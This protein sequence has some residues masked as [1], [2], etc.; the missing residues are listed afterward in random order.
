MPSLT[1]LMSRQCR[2]YRLIVALTPHLLDD[3]RRFH[4]FLEERHV[5][6]TYREH[7][8]GHNW[9]YWNEHLSE[10]LQQHMTAMP[11]DSSVR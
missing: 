3:N 10:A 9:A 4:A 6:H 7:E 2:S 1:S 11:K 5:P 8:G